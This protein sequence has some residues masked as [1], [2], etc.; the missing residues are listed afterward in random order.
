[1]IMTIINYIFLIVFL[2]ASVFVTLAF[3]NSKKTKKDIVMYVLMMIIY[4]GILADTVL[5]Q[6]FL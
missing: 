1:M 3:M 4:I 6:F 2:A 5:E